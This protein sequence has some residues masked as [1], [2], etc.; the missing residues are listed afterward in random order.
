MNLAEN[1]PIPEN[2]T[3]VTIPETTFVVSVQRVDPSTVPAKGLSFGAALGGFSPDGKIDPS[4][5]IFNRTENTPVTASV[6]LPLNIL[7]RTN[8]TRVAFSLFLTDSLFLRRMNEEQQQETIVGS[9]ILSASIVG[10]RLRNIN[11]RVELV[12]K[13]NNVSE[14]HSIM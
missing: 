6:L 14:Q 4:S 12:F 7:N 2:S 9:V 13:I 5:L 8:N 11:P 10:E 3:R 1:L